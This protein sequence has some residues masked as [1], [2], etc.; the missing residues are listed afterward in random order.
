MVGDKFDHSAPLVIILIPDFKK[1]PYAHV[2]AQG[3][4]MYPH[5]CKLKFRFVLQLT[6]T[7]ETYCHLLIHHKSFCSTTE[8]GY[9]ALME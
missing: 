3:R 2:Y 8:E 4:N 1:K 7:S 9:T 6:A 5:R